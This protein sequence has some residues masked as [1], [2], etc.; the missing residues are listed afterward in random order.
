MWWAALFSGQNGKL[1]RNLVW[2][3]IIATVI[4]IVVIIIVSANKKAKA[5]K[6]Q[7]DKIRDI[8]A[9]IVPDKLSYTES[10]YSSMADTIDNAIGTFSDDEEAIYEVFMRM[11][12]NSDVL[13]L[14]EAFGIRSGYDLFTIL[15]RNL[16]NDEIQKINSFLAQRNISIKI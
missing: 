2:I 5:N 13:K 1:I 15:H 6:V 16:N 8:E 10:Q 4:V 9:E 3:S 7:Q 11:Q 14:Q 12:T